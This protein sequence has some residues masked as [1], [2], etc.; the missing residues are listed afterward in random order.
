M[1][2][3]LDTNHLLYQTCGAIVSKKETWLF[4]EDGEPIGLLNREIVEWI[5]LPETHKN[6]GTNEEIYE[7]MCWECEQVS[8]IEQE[9]IE[10]APSEMKIVIPARYEEGVLASDEMVQLKKDIEIEFGE[11]IVVTL[12]AEL[13]NLIPDLTERVN[14]IYG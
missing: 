13:K 7:R 9:I 10:K 11:K 14:V 6:F 3:T 8:K 1:I 12:P 5:Y 2:K 4:N